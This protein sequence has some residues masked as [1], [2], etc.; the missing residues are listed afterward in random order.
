LEVF[1]SISKITIIKNK[2]KNLTNKQTNINQTNTNKHKH[3]FKQTTTNIPTND[4]K[5]GDF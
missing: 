2:Q 5:E 1:P 4:D 3:E